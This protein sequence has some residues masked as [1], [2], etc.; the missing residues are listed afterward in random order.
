MVGEIRAFSHERWVMLAVVVAAGLAC[1]L[2]A[3]A[4]VDA[5]AHGTGTELLDLVRAVSTSAL[6]VALLLGPGL[7]WRSASGR[8]I[9]LGFVPLPGLSL[10]VA[11]G[12]ASWLLA[13]SVEPKVVCFAVFGPALGLM[14]GALIGGGAEDLLGPEERR[15]L[16]LVSIVLGV[17][18]A[19]SIWSLSTVGE[20]YEG[21]ISRNLVAE[22][23]PD[24][25]ISYFIP[26]LIAHNRGPYSS[27]ANYLFAPYNFSSR[28]PLPGLAA[29]PIVFLTGGRPEL[30]VPEAAWSPFDAQGFMAYRIAMIAFGTTVL[31]SLWELVRR[32][33]GKKT[34]LLAVV[35][36]VATPFVYADLWFTWPKLLAASFVVLAAVCVL[37]RRPLRGGLLAG[38][39]YLM[40]PSALLGL[41]GVGLISLWGPHRPTWRRPN[42]K[43]T[44]LL[45]VGTGVI[46][47]GWRLGNGSHY[48][49][50]PFLEYFEQAYPSFHP[51]VGEWLQF[52][53]ASLANTVVP[54]FL[55]IAYSHSISINTLAHISPGVVHFFFQYW[56]GVPFGFAIVFL[57]LLL[58]SLWRALRHWPWAVV[59][60][61][62]IP[63]AFFLIY[64]GASITG[65]L[66]EGMQWWVPTVLA[67]VA[68]Q[69]RADG[70][71]WLRRRPVRAVLALRGLEVF[72]V[73]IGPVLGTHGLNPLGSG[74]TLDDLVCFMTIALLSVAL[75]ALTW[76]ETG[77]LCRVSDE[78]EDAGGG[79]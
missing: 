4:P 77:R 19:R 48:Y 45:L 21:T 60:T 36:G 35:L 27:D 74:Y 43:A 14:L 31:L 47:L 1:L 20:L 2:G 56:T 53:A 71:P 9:G 79:G 17:V 52:R 18:V 30:G 70:F 25:R 55:P 11:V 38:V 68:L 37:E 34:A 5:T 61:V 26:Q 32:L 59:A 13:G 8:E 44:V 7:L 58:W 10:L 76:R 40:H 28:G 72:A 12:L 23:R 69:Q 3:A 33:A 15:V 75:I 42:L 29:S 24:S 54:L 67:L 65:L 51:S 57:P 73:A 66:R 78:A 63:F 6:A 50:G 64:W 16:L 62:P 22:P 41:I 49:Q 46:F 39:G